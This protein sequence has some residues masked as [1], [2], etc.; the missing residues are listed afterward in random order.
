MAGG[1]TL[2]ILHIS[3]LHIKS[4]KSF[5]LSVVLDPLIKRVG[6]D[7]ENGLT[8]EIIVVTGDVGYSGLKKEYD[9]SIEFF[10]K[11]L[12]MLELPKERLFIVPGNHDVDLTQYNPS[13]EV[14]KYKNMTLL[15]LELE[16]KKYRN[17]RLKGMAP[18]F[19]YSK[20]YCPH[21]QSI[22]GNLIPFVH[23][24]EST[25]KKQ[26]GI[27]GLNSAWMC[28]NKLPDREKLAIGEYQVLKAIEELE[29]K[30][31]VDLTLNLFHHP[32][33]W[34]WPEDMKILKTHL[35]GSM[36]L[37][38]HLHDAGGG[39][40]KDL[41]GDYYTFQSGGTYLGSESS[42]PA[43][44]QYITLDWGNDK[45]RLDFRKY[46]KDDRT[47]CL[48]GETGKDGKRVF[49]NAGLQPQTTPRKSKSK[50]PTKPVKTL[51]E[52]PEAYKSWITDRCKTMDIDRLR[53]GSKVVSVDLPEVYI[54]LMATPPKKLYSRIKEDSVEQHKEERS[55]DIEELAAGNNYLLVRGEAGSGK[56]T[57]IKHMAYSIIRNENVWN[58]NDHLPVLIF[59][60]EMKAFGDANKGIV[61]NR[62]SAEK[63]LAAYVDDVAQNGLNCEI[64]RS[65]ATEGRIIFL[66]DGLDE[67]EPGFRDFVA[68]SLAAYRANHHGCKMIFSGRPHGVTGAAADRF[69][70][71]LVDV[72]DF[73]DEQIETFIRKW[74]LS[75]NGRES[76][77]GQKTADMMISELKTH[78]D[79]DLLKRNPLMLTAIC[80]LY[81][82]EKT[83][84]EQRAE[85]YKKFITH[86]L[87]KRFGDDHSR[88][89]KYVKELA[90]DMFMDGEKGVDGITAK[91]ILARYYPDD[92]RDE[93]DQRFATIENDSGLMRHESGK[94]R[95]SHLTFQE[96]LTATH[97]IDKEEEH[98]ANPIRDHWTD[99]RFKEVIEL[100]IGF[101]S[102]ENSGMAHRI[103]KDA[104]TE[105]DVGDYARWRLAAR[106]LLDIHEKS[107]QADTV[108]LAALK[109]REIIEKPGEPKI[110]TD[111]GDCLGWLG[112][113]R[114]LK[115]F[116][117][118]DGGSYSLEDIGD[119]DIPPFEIS[120]FPVTNRWYGEFVASG[121][122]KN[123]EFWSHE[124]QMW[125]DKTGATQPGNWD[126]RKWICP[127]APVVG[128]CWYEAE[129]FTKW[130]NQAM[131]GKEKD[132]RTYTYRLPTEH[133]WQAA[134]A[135]KETRKY[136]WGK[137]W[138]GKRCN[139]YK[140]GIEKTSSVGVFVKGKSQEEIFD[141]SGNV[142]EWTSSYYAEDKKSVFILRGGSWFN[143]G[144]VYF[145]CADRDLNFPDDRFIFVG[146]RCAR[147]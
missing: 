70:D 141:M 71:H 135:G 46:N 8:A 61:P 43:R 142:W 122:Y 56:T 4:D 68:M 137:K 25:S 11:L 107:R 76:I 116:V 92:T 53:E 99:G 86:L 93:L 144:S 52:I 24:Y 115:E 113:T 39:I 55:R 91:K 49:D 51:P 104:L 5:D 96:F 31:P 28:R 117:P 40:S 44:Y 38:G 87:T 10:D 37:S 147:T 90:H 63:L 42:W 129:G 145:R 127:N 101:L 30:G 85:L 140:T 74:F 72:Q 45:I 59:L 111:A 121:G 125:L 48:D 84:P 7:K 16:T 9:R 15:S 106:S 109:M 118:I 89:H 73:N 18:Y 27:V 62:L 34:L 79:I 64:I 35:K 100:Y 110:L 1:V 143:D 26:I 78:Q 98:Y 19:K 124:G 95:F 13:E 17:D 21:L 134:A 80:I 114:D 133:E 14:L 88:V 131:K 66:V 32:L 77:T 120:K 54:P 3:D 33:H 81:N 20:T 75:V 130:L 136:P 105:K 29:G 102:L 22:H 65:Y 132:G 69:G 128:V 97:M 138:D 146:F 58:F 94:F 108:A 126:N 123:R 82:D 12:K 41:Q 50:K 60:K 139:N 112:D 36:I 83:L 57:L 2:Q 119:K 67:I 103:V 47:W 23:R 6:E